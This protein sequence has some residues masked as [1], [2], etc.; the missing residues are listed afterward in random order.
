M[1]VILL[2]LIFIATC[3]ADVKWRREKINDGSTEILWQEEKY[4]TIHLL[5]L[6]FS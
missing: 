1:G 2:I 5:I 3:N 4:S 6:E